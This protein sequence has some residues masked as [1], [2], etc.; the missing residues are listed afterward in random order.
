M[1]SRRGAR[2][3]LSAV[4]FKDIEVTDAMLQR[5]DRMWETQKRSSK[6][7]STSKAA[8]T[9]TPELAAK[10]AD[11]PA[12]ATTDRFYQLHSIITLITVFPLPGSRPACPHKRIHHLPKAVRSAPSINR[13]DQFI[14]H[15]RSCIDIVH[16]SQTTDSSRNY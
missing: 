16:P 5:Y 10:S 4:D 3:R 9:S 12:A 2:K 11:E 1:K 6:A 13:H 14:M 15:L 8:A 7:T